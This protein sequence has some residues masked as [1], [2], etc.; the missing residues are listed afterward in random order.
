MGPGPRG[1]AQLNTRIRAGMGLFN[2]QSVAVSFPPMYP[3]WEAQSAPVTV[4][5][6]VEGPL[7]AAPCWT[8][9]GLTGPS[10]HSVHPALLSK[11][12][13]KAPLCTHPDT[14]KPCGSKGGLGCNHSGSTRP[15]RS[16]RPTMNPALT[17]V[18]RCHTPT[19]AGPP[20]RD[21]D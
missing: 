2:V 7:S 11:T 10:T 17:H 14:P 21:G 13:G 3:L 12:W 16:W 18:P 20:P 4:A 8:P 6:R 1:H 5:S 15:L 19:A 9:L